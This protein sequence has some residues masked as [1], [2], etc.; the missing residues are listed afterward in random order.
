MWAPPLQLLWEAL[1]L[2]QQ[3]SAHSNSF[4]VALNEIFLCKSLGFSSQPNKSSE[5]QLGWHFSQGDGPPQVPCLGLV[6]SRPGHHAETES[7]KPFV[8]S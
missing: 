5:S 4:G 3:G 2:A 7:G 1:Y 8:I 6:S